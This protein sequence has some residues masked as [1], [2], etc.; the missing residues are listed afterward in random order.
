MNEDDRAD[1]VSVTSVDDTD[2]AG[3]GKSFI[4]E[5]SANNAREKERKPE[6]LHL[7]TK[8]VPAVVTLLGGGIVT[9]DVFLQQRDFKD[10]LIIILISLI[11]FL[12]AGELVKLLLDR[13]ELPNPDAVDADGNVIQKGKSGEDEA[14]EEGSEDMGSY[15]DAQGE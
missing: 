3:E 15:A 4:A 7:K 13:I 5:V 10:S 12:V 2:D 11:V 14:L 8:P 6:P 9:A 1:G